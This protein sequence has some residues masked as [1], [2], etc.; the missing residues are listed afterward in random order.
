MK[1]SV[2][3]SMKYNILV[4]IMFLITENLLYLYGNQTYFKIN[5]VLVLRGCPK[6]IW[7]YIFLEHYDR[8]LIQLS[9]DR[10]TYIARSLH[11]LTRTQTIHTY[12]YVYI[13]SFFT[14]IT[15]QLNEINFSGE[16]F[17]IF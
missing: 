11:N 17:L 6:K 1:Q 13:H 10:Q 5:I 4:K 15:S 7:L 2:L 9:T 14:A 3:S 8:A 12:M 16:V